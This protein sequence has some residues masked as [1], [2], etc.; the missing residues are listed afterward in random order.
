MKKK[1]FGYRRPATRHEPRAFDRRQILGMTAAGVLGAWS[2]GLGASP[3]RPR[4][5]LAG[6]P[7]R[8]PSET[9]NPQRVLVIGAG[10]SGLAAARSLADAGHDV[11]VIESR[12]RIGGRID[13][14]S[15]WADAP[16]DLGASWIHGTDDNPIAQIADQIG[17][18]TVPTNDNAA[19]IYDFDGDV[20][21]NAQYLRLMQLQAQ[22]NQ[23]VVE[24]Q[25]AD[26]D[27]PLRQ[28]VENGIGFPQL[29]AQD[30]RFVNFIIN[31]V[32]Q[33]LAGSATMLSTYWYDDP[34]FFTGPE[35][36]F[37][38]G[39]RVITDH[40][41]EGLAIELGQT[42]SEIAIDSEGVTV[43]T[44]GG[45]FSGGCAIVTLP[46]GVLKA[47]TVQ[48]SPGLPS[49]IQQA[50]DT[51][52]M[53]VLNKAYLRFPTAFWPQN[54]DWMQQV[55]QNHGEWVNWLNIDRVVD[56][57]ILAGFNV[58]DFGTQLESLPDQDIVANGMEKL[59]SIFGNS[60]PD[61]LDF[62]ITRWA[63]DPHTRGSYSF[64]PSGAHPSLRDALGGSIDGRIFFAGEATQREHYPT[65]H[66]A[67]LS[68]L[69]AASQ[70][71][72]TFSGHIFSDGFE[73]G[74]TS[75]WS[76]LA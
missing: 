32:E 15:H 5:P 11:L 7:I 56:Q 41:A 12:N 70:I 3:N 67:Y 61:P 39:Y 35:V 10:V 45:T 34:G 68:G 9:L 31:E 23:I 19:E 48:F 59:R 22:V 18:Q 42:V 17:A 33:G 25:D 64:L 49:S 40:L 26:V 4:R 54:L 28:T 52:Q 8:Q 30:Q 20:L 60:I 47:G 66:G 74:D 72:K 1:I 65:V 46:L 36:V 58:A 6:R 13:T 62:Q 37:P 51:L 50:I 63:S 71:T 2:R 75:E 24:G 44:Q 38:G 27:Q 43:T 76:T 29:S 73:S 55:P 57:P 14:S 16:V 53:G 69:R 21:S